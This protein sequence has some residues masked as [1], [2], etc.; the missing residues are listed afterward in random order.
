MFTTDN[1]IRAM[2]MSKRT[3]GYTSFIEDCIGKE[4]TKNNFRWALQLKRVLRQDL[5]R[6]EAEFKKLRFPNVFYKSVLETDLV[7][8]RK[9]LAILER[10]LKDFISSNADYM[11]LIMDIVHSYGK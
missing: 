11:D 10:S 7:R 2:V 3:P 1:E 8:C 9:D 5:D 4:V 6:K